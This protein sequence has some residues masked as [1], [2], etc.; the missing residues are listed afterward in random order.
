LGAT[1]NFLVAEFQMLIEAGAGE[2]YN[3]KDYAWANAALFGKN[4][5]GGDIAELLTN[6]MT[7]KAPL[8]A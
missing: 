2:F 3:Y 1:A 8:L 5:V 6:N 4:G 7:H